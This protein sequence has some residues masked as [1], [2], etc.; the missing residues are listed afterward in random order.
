[1]RDQQQ[2]RS[3]LLDFLFGAAR[4]AV[5]DIRD[6]L[7]FEGWFG[8][9]SSDMPPMGTDA[10]VDWAND[11]TQGA[12]APATLGDFEKQWAVREPAEQA[13]QAPERG[14]DR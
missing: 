14:I 4:D 6:K 10:W 12:S 13:A 5:A 7:V 1:M 9:S 2:E 11:A 8:R 3:G